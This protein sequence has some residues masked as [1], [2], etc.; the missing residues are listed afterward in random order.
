[1]KCLNSKTAEKNVE[2]LTAVQDT[3]IEVLKTTNPPEE[4]LEK[5]L[6]KPPLKITST[7]D[8]LMIGVQ[9]VLPVKKKLK[10]FMMPE[11][12]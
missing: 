5:F 1:M 3:V 9:V 6:S 8:Q 12:I 11:D 7:G 2:T 10:Q 4:I